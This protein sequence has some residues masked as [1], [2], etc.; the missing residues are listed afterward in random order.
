M[1]VHELIL[2]VAVCVDFLVVAISYGARG[3]R[4]S[5]LPSVILSAV[6]AAVLFLSLLCSAQLTEYIAPSVCRILGGGVLCALGV[7]NLFQTAI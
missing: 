2:A 5:A 4:L 6:G 3:I 7:T 1:W